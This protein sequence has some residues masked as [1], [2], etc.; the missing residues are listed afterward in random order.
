MKARALTPENIKN[1]EEINPPPEVMK[2]LQIFV[3][4]GD[5]IRL[6][7]R[8]WTRVKTAQ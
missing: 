7:D 3:D 5:A 6:Y 1:S 8:Q 2:R 4:I